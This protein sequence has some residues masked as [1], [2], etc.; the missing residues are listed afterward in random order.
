MREEAAAS[1]GVCKFAGS[2]HKGNLAEEVLST[3]PLRGVGLLL[4]VCQLGSK[5]H[6]LRR[7]HSVR[8]VDGATN[9]TGL[10]EKDSKEKGRIAARQL[11]V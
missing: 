11:T 8:P 7:A 10:E 2:R 1:L 5:V 3:L 9:G 6:L 4:E